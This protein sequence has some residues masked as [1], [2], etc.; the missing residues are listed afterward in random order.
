MLTVKRILFDILRLGTIY[1]IPGAALLAIGVWFFLQLLFGI[2]LGGFLNTWKW[3]YIVVMIFLIAY[4][5]WILTAN[6][7]VIWALSIKI[8]VPFSRLETAWW[9]H[10]F[11]HKYR[12]E[13][14]NWDKE[15]FEQEYRVAEAA[16]AMAKAFA[17]AFFDR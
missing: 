4:D 2:Q 5:L 16:N 3:T 1:M 13:M 14:Q 17:K 10:D 6:L 11:M 15:K 7:L 12:Q 8:G 9:T